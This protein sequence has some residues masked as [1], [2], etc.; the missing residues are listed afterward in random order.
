MK[1]LFLT[2]NLNNIV[3]IGDEKV[4]VKCDNSNHFMDK[5]KEEAQKVDSFVFV[6]SDPDNYEK[7]STYSNLIVESLKL[8]GYNVTT[9]TVLDHRFTED[10]K[11]AVLNADLLFFMGGHVPTQN[12]YMKELKL[13][14]ILSDYN[15]VVVGQSA[16]SMNCSENVYVQ[17]EYEQDAVPNFQKQISGLGLTKIVVM[18]H[19]N[20]AKEDEFEGKTVWDMCLEDSVKYPHYGIADSGFIEIKDGVATLYGEGYT[21]NNGKVAKICENGHFVEISQT[22]C[23]KCKN[24]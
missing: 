3:K 10:A 23:R 6:A 4:A 22:I 7:T 2:S 13:K 11:S 16:G 9:V 8:E 19:I 15:G 14:N 20:K 21:F 12:K 5:L 24:K 1:A 17:P 18:P